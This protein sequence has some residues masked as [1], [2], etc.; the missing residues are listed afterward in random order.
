M[1]V[2]EAILWTAYVVVPAGGWGL[3]HGRPIGPLGL[4]VLIAI[5]WSHAFTR[6]IPLTRLA[7]ALLG[8]KLAIGLWVPIDHGFVA[9]YYANDGWRP[10]E[11]RSL[12]FLR[13]P[14]TRIDD[15][16]EFRHAGRPFP[17][18][19][20][21]D[22][23]R[24]DHLPDRS[25]WPVS[26]AWQGWL[27]VSRDERTRLYVAAPIDVGPDGGSPRTRAALEV[28][29]QRVLELGAGAARNESALTLAPGWHR[30]DVRYRG[31]SS[32][33]TPVQLSVGTTQDGR[34]RP[35]DAAGIDTR[36]HPAWRRIADRIVRVVS[37]AL[38]GVLTVGLGGWIL[39]SVS[40]MLARLAVDAPARGERRSGER[41]ATAL[42]TM[43]VAVYVL[44]R[45]L[46]RGLAGL[47]IILSRGDDW[48][49]YETYAREIVLHGP[50]MTLGHPIG[51][52]S[53]FYYQPLYPYFLAAVHF[54]A[55]EDFFGVHVAQQLLLASTVWALYRLAARLFEP[56]AGWLTLALATYFVVVVMSF[57]RPP[58]PEFASLLP[59][60]LF[61]PLVAWWSLALVRFTECPS[62]SWGAWTGLLGGVTALTRTTLLAA[63]PLILPLV[64][65]G[66]RIRR[67]ASATVSL[68]IFVVCLGG[69]LGLVVLRNGMVSHQW[70][71][72]PTSGGVNLQISNEPP[73]GVDVSRSGAR[74]IHRYLALG[75]QARATLEYALQAP[76]PFVE[77]L[78]SKAAFMLG[79]R[80][81]SPGGGDRSTAS[82]S[83]LG[84][85]M[86][87]WIS[88]AAGIIS[89]LTIAP[90][91]ADPR[92]FVPAAIAVSHFVVLVVVGVF[93]YG[94]RVVHPMYALL[95]PYS[96]LALSRLW[97]LARRRCFP[98]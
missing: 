11:E 27:H 30:L 33:E 58:S 82:A 56:P 10:P 46:R 51:E 74:P 41:A 49:T 67:R 28:D 75:P 35:F 20:F 31:P 9:R 79:L 12:D 53:P 16:L 68:I 2:W 62:R 7:I 73:A 40:R 15:R 87:V 39:W 23:L 77:G 1:P 5:W 91:R 60:T 14:A 38:D 70:R 85:M 4:A 52:A 92:S 76:R 97:V 37:S 78:A 90:L 17:L 3:L 80:A 69:A 26:V 65:A 50:L 29:G 45:A 36:P 72:V 22:S 21:N 88:G 59:E 18:Y 63:I 84:F 94:Y 54:L 98:T 89:A 19:F 57:R 61:V 32:P 96:G 55:G 24:F 66:L 86:L 6:R 42:V 95:L 64:V 8:A 71:L 25:R 44:V 34:D 13:L 47:P 48:L 81:N 93:S 83:E 43:A